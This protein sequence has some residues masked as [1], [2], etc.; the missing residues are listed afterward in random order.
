MNAGRGIVQVRVLKSH[1]I[2]KLQRAILRGISQPGE[3]MK[4]LFAVVFLSL[5]SV[6][7]FASTI[8]CAGTEPFWSLSVKGK[9]VWFNSPEL[10]QP[11]ALKILNRNEAFGYA[12]GHTFIIKTRYSR[13]TVIGGTCNDGMSDE[14]YT[15]NVAFEHDGKLLGG[16][17]TIRE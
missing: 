17:C 9:F 3:P 5:F 1:L 11:M 6:S 8:E 15:H 13:M 2:S 16:C 7:S 12:P 14:E 10:T 4:T